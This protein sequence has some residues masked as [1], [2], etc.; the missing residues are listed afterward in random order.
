MG[1]STSPEVGW[2][3]HIPG[4]RVRVGLVAGVPREGGCQKA[5]KALEASIRTCFHERENL[6]E[7]FAL[8]GDMI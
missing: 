1:E 8:S 5:S 3:R 7:D 6:L 4:L 2:G